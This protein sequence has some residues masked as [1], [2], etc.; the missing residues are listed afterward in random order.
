MARLYPQKSRRSTATEL[1]IM[2]GETHL[3]VE[4]REINARSYPDMPIM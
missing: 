4:C 2:D 1:R 3:S